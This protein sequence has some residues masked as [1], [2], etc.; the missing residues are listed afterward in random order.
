MA[1]DKLK[2]FAAAQS[3]DKLLEAL[4][5]LEHRQLSEPER[6]ARAAMSDVIE[7]RHS[8]TDHMDA[9]YGDDEYAGTYTE[10]LRSA[11]ERSRA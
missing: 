1:I 5:Q 10:A 11:L 8:L 7:E 6:M 3:T 9:I 4:E 2:A